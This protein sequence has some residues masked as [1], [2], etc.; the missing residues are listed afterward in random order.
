[1][2]NLI[3]DYEILKFFFQITST[4]FLQTHSGKISK[5]VDWQADVSMFLMVQI[6]S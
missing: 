3:R 2:H 1:M 4:D 5:P 6:S